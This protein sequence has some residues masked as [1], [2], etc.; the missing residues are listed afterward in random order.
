MR[1]M[2]PGRGGRRDWR[3][4]DDTTQ[5]S[6]VVPTACRTADGTR[7]GEPGRACCSVSSIMRGSIGRWH[8][9]TL[10]EGGV[11]GHVDMSGHVGHVVGEMDK[12]MGDGELQ[13]FLLTDESVAPSSGRCL[14]IFGK[15]QF[16]K[17][18]T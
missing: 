9:T 7:D 17:D 16:G 2:G 12:M 4:A 13:N 10:S 6:P 18:N 5:C 11:I 15:A 3:P 14:A 1:G 8:I